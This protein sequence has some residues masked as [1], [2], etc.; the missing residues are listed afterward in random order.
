LYIGRMSRRPFLGLCFL[1]L[2]FAGAPASAAPARDPFALPVERY[3]LKSG[4][5]VLLH[6]DASLPQVVVSLWFNVGS[7]DERPGRTGFAHLYEHLMFMGTKNVPGGGFDQIMEAEGGA[8]NAS[9][10]ND[11]TYYYETGPAHLLSTFLYLEAERLTT[12]PQAMTAQKVALQREV[13]RNER[14][15]S[16]ENRPYGMAELALPAAL[17]PK[18]HPYSWPVIGSHEDLIAASTADVKDFFYQ[19]YAAGNATLMVAGDINPTETR[20]LIEHYF[21]WMPKAEHPALPRVKAPTAPLVTRLEMRDANVELPRVYLVWHAPPAGTEA[22]LQT[23]VLAEVLGKGRGSR[24][25]RSLVFER[26]LAQEVEVTF[27]EQVLGSLLIVELTANQ[28]VKP[29][30]LISAAEAELRRLAG[31][32]SGPGQIQDPGLSAAELERARSQILTRWAREIEPLTDRARVIQT[33]QALWG[34]ATVLPKLAQGV[35]AVDGK[36]LGERA[37]A[38][39]LGDPARRLTLSV[40][41]APAQPGPKDAQAGKAAQPGPKDKDP[42]PAPADDGGGDRPAPQPPIDLSKRPAVPAQKPF[43]PPRAARFPVGGLDVLLV[44][45]KGA[46]LLDTQVVIPA[47]SASDPPGQAGLARAVAALITEG[48]G[49]R[50]AAQVAEDLERVGATLKAEVTEDATYIGLTVLLSR[51]AEAAPILLDVVARPRLAEEEWRRVKVERLAE[52]ARRRVEPPYQADRALR[53]ALFG[54]EHPY[55]QP[56]L[57]SEGAIAKLGLSDLRVFHATHY[58][59]QR[60]MLIFTGDVELTAERAQELAAPYLGWRDPVLPPGTAPLAVRKGAPRQVAHRLVLVDRKGAPQSEVR[61]GRLAGGRKDPDRAVATVAEVILG[62]SF[63]SRLNQNLRE[64]HG[65]AYGAASHFLRLGGAG[66]FVAR[67]AVR[68]DATAEA[69]AEVLKELSRMDEAAPDRAELE[70]G[71]RTVL[72]GLLEVCEQTPHLSRVFAEVARYGLPLDE[73][74]RFSAGVKGAAP[75]SLKRVVRAAMRPQEMT[76]VVVGDLSQVEGPL[77]AL[78]RTWA[79][80]RRDAEGRLLP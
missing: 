9:T 16:Y 52:A 36:V 10:S 45:R 29:Q 55:G 53:A 34:D 12:L 80:E 38:L 1:L 50:G 5:T 41:P 28:G 8:N 3:Q 4:M 76:V 62:G 68:T 35:R 65:W 66:A 56:P 74:S 39:G 72:Q 71:R 18:G 32:G 6:R 46:A 2:V 78:G 69:V 26:R 20:R 63:T 70:K 22:A 30:D 43:T 21:G 73:L 51:A 19:H 49:A 40:L 37:R 67:A 13:V 54:E 31:P 25:Y 24:L 59:P 47:G 60:A 7:K 75:E 48:A 44:Q 33:L 23:Q 58:L 64:A 57:G 11:A 14:R 17:Y 42:V 61:V 27:E 77:R 15:Q 79:I